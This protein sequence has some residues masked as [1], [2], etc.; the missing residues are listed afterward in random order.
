[1]DIYPI[2]AQ[3]LE[4]YYHINGKQLERHYKEHLSDFSTWNAK[5]HAE[6]YLIFP[7]NIGENISIDETSFSDGDLYTI[8]TNKDKKCQKGS[9]IAIVEGTESKKV[10]EALNKI[11]KEQRD[12]VKE[13]TLDMSNSMDKIIRQSFTQADLVI[14]RFHVQMLVNDAI[15]E[16]RI[17]HRWEAMEEENRQKEQTKK[18]N[19]KYIPE[20][21]ENGDTK[22]QLLA[23]SRYLLFKSG[24]KWTEKQKIRAKI[25]FE[26]YPEIAKAYSIAHSLRIIYSKPHNKESGKE[27]I[28]RWYK[29]IE[30]TNIPSLKTIAKTVQKNED[31][32]VNYFINRSTNASAES[33]NAKI[34][35][36]RAALRGVTDKKFF[37]FRL[38]NIYA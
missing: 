21:L 32:I 35:F 17:K 1:M 27:S 11:P 29:K 26:L 36:F 4:R 22:K 28:K 8:V 38:S 37:L 5:D 9:L 14:D 23:R 15:Q 2:P 12:M 19:K 20:I 13:A 24:D 25:L 30:E 3:S 16:L 18:E 6:E 10:I 34:K 7:E 33:F 31:E